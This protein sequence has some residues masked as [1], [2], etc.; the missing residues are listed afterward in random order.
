MT[1][2]ENIMENVRWYAKHKELNYAD[3]EIFKRK[4]ARVADQEHYERAIRELMEV[5]GL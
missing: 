4:I 5:C 2:L 1:E 3:Y